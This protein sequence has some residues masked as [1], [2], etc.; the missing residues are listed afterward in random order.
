MRHDTG[1][2]GCPFYSKES[3]PVS[4]P[5]SKW[6]G[7][8]RTADYLGV[9]AMTIWRWERDPELTFPTATVIRGRKYWSRDDLD[10]WMRRM[11]TGKASATEKVA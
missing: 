10:A 9:T 11:A 1:H 5:E 8:A 2:K 3:Q 6:L 7:G 4:K